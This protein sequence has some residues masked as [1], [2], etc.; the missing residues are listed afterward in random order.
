MFKSIR[1]RL[2][3]WYTTVFA[4][5]FVLSAWTIYEYVGHTL[6]DRLD[7]SLSS[8]MKWTTTRFEKYLSRRES[9]EAARED[10]FEHASFH[11]SKEY[12]EIWDSAGM[13]FYH[14]P[15]LGT[16]TLARFIAVPEYLSSSLT[17]IT[18]FSRHD[19]RAAIRR[20]SYGL[21]L[22]AMPI[23][24]ITSSESQLVSVFMWLGPV[25]I[26]IATGGG[27]FLA[28]KS[29]SKINQV[30]E[31]AQRITAD[32]LYDRIPEHGTQDEIGRIISTFN[33]MISRL[34]VSFSQMKQFSADASHELR[35]P[36]AVV[37]TQLESA[38]SNRVSG[39]EIK[40]IIANCLDET[41]R[42]SSVVENLLLLAKADS[43]QETLR[44][45][46]VDL[47]KLISQMY[48][49]SIIIASQKKIA[50]TL[51]PPEEI[52]IQGD[53][54]R[55]RQMFLNL[56]DNAVKYSHAHGK[57]AMSLTQHDGMARISVADTGIGIPSAEIPRIFDRFYRVDHARTREL[58]GAGLGLAI[59]KWIVHAHG[60]TISV[61]SEPNKGSEFIILLPIEKD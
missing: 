30:I 59:I 22:L 16:D 10:I 26:L 27:M 5:T 7:E 12:C 58:G 44:R 13:L 39:V 61:L 50:V 38:L 60:G 21:I 57:M 8:E 1:V 51:V 53:E 23:E 48:D 49:E 4:L 46:P 15:N 29:F 11:P 24:S 6:S 36:L 20:D 2:A 55:L 31:T 41:L 54:H 37:R 47:K 17:T 14:S 28:K 33:D 9:A 56:I 19:I 18:S 40:K 52:T 32:R 35:T 34:D 45:D 3:M 25:V 43:K 42:M